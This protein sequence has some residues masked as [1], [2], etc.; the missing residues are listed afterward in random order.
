MPKRSSSASEPTSKPRLPALREAPT[1]CP[2]A[3]EFENPLRYIL[4][5][6]EEAEKYGICCIQPPP[7]WKPP[8]MIDL[9][10]LK[11]PTRVQK[12]N[13][14]LVRRVQR[15]KFMKELTEFSDASGTPLSKLPSVSGRELDLHLLYTHV[16]RFGGFEGASASRKWSE[17]AEKMNMH[18]VAT[19]SLA[20][21]LKKHYTTFLLPFEKRQREAAKAA[22]ARDPSRTAAAEEPAQQQLPVSSGGSLMSRRVSANVSGAEVVTLASH[23]AERSNAVED[24][25][26]VAYEPPEQGEEKCEVCG[27]GEDNATMLLCDRCSCGFHIG[28]LDPPLSAVP[29]GEWCCSLCLSEQF[30]FGSGRIFK[31]HQYEK[32][33]HAFK[34]AFFESLFE[35]GTAKLSKKSKEAGR[36]HDA[37]ARALSRV[38]LSELDVPVEEV[39]WQFWNIVTTPDKPLEVRRRDHRCSTQYQ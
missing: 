38:M 32:Q 20:A 16:A 17:I 33:A 39:E 27:S 9:N 19:S 26:V 21:A 35:T 31:F 7:T 34:H 13:E 18:D 3:A 29:A 2:T 30:G 11:V 22:P 12:I 25:V 36:A 8:F 10:K 4:S 15:L 37:D 14:L 5:V 24:D 6:R 1:F 28:C 23:G